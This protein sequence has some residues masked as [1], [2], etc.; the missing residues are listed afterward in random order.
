MNAQAPNGRAV[1]V[2]VV[3]AHNR[4]R[5]VMAGALLQSYLGDGFEVETAGFGPSGLPA[6]PEA[7]ELLAER[8][9]DVSGHRSTTLTPALVGR[10]DVVLTAEKSQVLAV[11]ADLGGDFDRTFT[12]PE[13]LEVHSERPRGAAYL[14]H[15]V[16]EIADP[17]GRSEQV[18][19]A[20]FGQIDDCCRGVAAALHRRAVG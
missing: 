10:A 19:F 6:M 2:L 17:T 11:V 15:G 4:T 12:L 8:G 3:C 5:S 20:S 13:Y 9:L 14:R 18:W 16:P 1:R 7:V